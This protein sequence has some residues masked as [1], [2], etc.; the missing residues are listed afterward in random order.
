MRTAE[1]TWSSPVVKHVTVAAVL[2]C[3][4]L[5]LAFA[6]YAALYRPSLNSDFMAFWAFPRFAASQP[7]A[8]IYDAAALGGFERALYPGFR[9]FYPYL[10]PPTLLLATWW[11][12]CFG[13]AWAQTIW[14]IAGVAAL[15]ASAW[16]FFGP[17]RKFSAL[18]MLACPAALI[19]GATGETAFFT[20]ALLLGGFAA[21]P[22]RPI[23]AGALF[24]L[25]TLKPQLG[26]LIPF[27]L[28]GLGAWRTI[29]SAA[30]VAL[31]LV[32]LSCLTFPPPLWLVWAHTLPAYQADY[33]AAVHQLNL[34]IIVT[35][36]AN[37]VVLGASPEAAWA[38]Q[39]VCSAAIAATTFFSFRQ[40]RYDLAVALLFT[41]MFLAVP[42][43]YAYDTL[44]LTVAL[45]RLLTGR[46]V[47]P[48]LAILGGVIYLG[49]FL[50][51]TPARGNFLYAPPE[52]IL[53]GAIIRLAFAKPYVEALSYEHQSRRIRT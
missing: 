40:A 24:G 35:P 52:M 31:A 39:A 44:P 43:A 41:G 13:F 20:T 53:Y 12:K 5:T 3:A 33:F 36:A 51:L 23:L 15:A 1:T 7:I 50:L 18:A 22:T 28:L 11:L 42:H 34:N 8:K 30:V 4:S 45:A 26:F 2:G 47:G 48:A 16:R 38:L 6:I 27:A 46:R 25:L 37:A 9:S 29:V 32:A 49:P 17:S 14:T 19:A 10:Y 21:L